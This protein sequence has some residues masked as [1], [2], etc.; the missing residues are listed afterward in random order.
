MSVVSLAARHNL[1]VIEDAAQGMAVTYNGKNVGTFG[2][3][4]CMSF[5]ADKT[6]T[7]G[8]GGAL[9]LNDEALAEKCV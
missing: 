8:E 1:S 6:I 5:F 2:D 9:L 4:G 7:T 3:I